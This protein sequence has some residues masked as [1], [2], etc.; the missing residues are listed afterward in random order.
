M[1][2][3]FLAY[4]FIKSGT[5]DTLGIQIMPTL[6]IGSKG[7]LTKLSLSPTELIE[8]KCHLA[9]FHHA[10]VREE[11]LRYADLI[12]PKLSPVLTLLPGPPHSKNTRPD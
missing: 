4:N 3:K 11:L 12:C 9:F 6:Q 10:G 8:Y 5:N 2:Q 7:L 1:R